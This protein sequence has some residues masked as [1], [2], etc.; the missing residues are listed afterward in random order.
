MAS[1]QDSGRCNSE[2]PFKESTKPTKF[3]K[4]CD[5]RAAMTVRHAA[6]EHGA[7]G[8]GP[9][10]RRGAFAPSLSDIFEDLFR[11]AGQR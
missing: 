1:V 5:K 9:G 8:G 10:V 2:S 4:D 3:F 7:G 11:H 6:F